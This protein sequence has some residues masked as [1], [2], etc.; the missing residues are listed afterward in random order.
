MINSS[1]D[2]V[3]ELNMMVSRLSREL[4][5]CRAKN[6]ALERRL[7]AMDGLLDYVIQKNSHKDVVNDVIKDEEFTD[8]VHDVLRID[9]CINTPCFQRLKNLT[10]GMGDINGK[11]ITCVVI[12]PEFISKLH[13]DQVYTADA[14][15]MVLYG[16]YEYTCSRLA[17]VSD[18]NPCVDW[19]RLV[20]FTNLR[21]LTIKGNAYCGFARNSSSRT[22]RHLKIYMGEYTYYNP[23]IDCLNCPATKIDLNLIKIK[24]T[25]FYSE[26]S[27]LPR[28][29][30]LEILE[31]IGNENNLQCSDIVDFLPHCR[32][33]KVIKG[34]HGMYNPT[35]DCYCVANGISLEDK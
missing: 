4:A 19:T 13:R 18:T 5:E 2:E 31:F 3:S 21:K 7:V 16:I 12:K 14:T 27:W 17:M 25:L 22:L 15:R 1:D 32:N 35:L 29:P 10:T 20:E 33:M 28:F 24:K 8:V 11:L 34:G 9:L 26:C 23:R 30:N 6:E